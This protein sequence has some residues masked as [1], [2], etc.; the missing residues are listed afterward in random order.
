MSTDSPFSLS[1]TQPRRRVGKY[2]LQRLVGRGSIAEVYRATSPDLE[3]EV[4]LKVIH[5]HVDED[6][7]ILHVQERFLNVLQAVSTLEHPNIARTLDFGVHDQI[8]YVVTD[9]IEG[10]S[11]RD[12]LS[13]RRSGLQLDLALAFFRQLADA[14]AYAH[15]LGI[16]HQSFRPGNIMLEDGSHPIIVDF[17]LLR[18]LGDDDLTTVQFSPHAPTYMSP[19]QAAGRGVTPQADI[20]SL[21]IVLYEM[22]TG[23]VPFKGGNAARILVQHLQDAPRPPGELNPTLPPQV[24]AAIL[25]ALAK[26]PEDRFAPVREMVEALEQ[27]SGDDYDTINLRKEDAR[28]I[29]QRLR[30]AQQSSAP[31]QIAGRSRLSSGPSRT[32][33]IAAGVLLI[34]AVLIVIA[35]LIAGGQGA[36]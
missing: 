10:P 35:L 27:E 21:G 11:L 1:P 13:E 5:P 8:F 9:F 22:V 16:L 23:D 29:R 7:D 14:L 33:I 24:E 18:A 34:I 32:V 17:G 31:R 12:M 2:E 30:D 19:E 26:K 25:R 20:Y 3:Q 15:N 4:A 6:E 28:E 36:G